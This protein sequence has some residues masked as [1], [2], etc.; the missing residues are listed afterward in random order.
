MLKSVFL[1]GVVLSLV[2]FTPLAFG[3][4]LQKAALL[5]NI[6]VIYDQSASKSVIASVTL[7]TV[8]NNAIL[9]P[10]I[11]LDK[12]SSHDDIRFVVFTN[13][14]ECVMGVSSDEQCIMIKF[15]LETIKG[16]GGINTVQT[17]AK[18]IGDELISDLN[19][20]LNLNAKFHSIWV[21]GGGSTDIASM[22]EFN[23]VG[24]GT[25]SATY[26][27]PKQET[28]ILFS[29]LTELI[30]AQE[31]RNSGGF[32]EVARQLA[33]QPGSTISVIIT[34]DEERPLFLFKVSN[35]YKDRTDD[36]SLIN[37]LGF[38]DISELE[39]SEL[40]EDYFVPLN[41]VVRVIISP[42]NPTQ[43][44]AVKSNVI[45]KLTDV[46][47][48]SQAGWFF[49]S[50]SYDLIDARFLFGEEPS[51][52]TDKLVMELGPRDN[53]NENGFFSVQDIRV[54]GQNPNEQYV[55]LAV[56]IV[57]AIGAALFYLKGYKRNH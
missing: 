53:Q 28:D 2:V 6:T 19:N 36:I 27:M 3:Q 22:S 50:T 29:N 18:A 8:N 35:E 13:M 23:T 52:S 25:A 38:F 57:A 56:I 30:L 51:V 20:M 11:L 49:S 44:N 42:E 17:N 37:P 5:E 33:S 34:Q 4:D 15:N 48:V 12:L 10:D 45:T 41:S 46:E 55:I 24:A 31:I 54:D 14:G 40:F 1:L 21:E 47:D 16:D 39:R 43:V 26:T 9:I 32:Y 7:E